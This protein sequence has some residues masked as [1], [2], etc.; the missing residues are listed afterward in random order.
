M[1]IDI[2]DALAE[3]IKDSL[4]TEAHNANAGKW[5]R[6]QLYA[7]ARRHF[8]SDA[9][10]GQWLKDTFTDPPAGH[11]DSRQVINYLLACLEYLSEDEFMRLGYTKSAELMHKTMWRDYPEQMGELARIGHEFTKEQIR[12][13]VKDIKEGR[14]TQAPVPVPTP[15]N[16]DRAMF[17]ELLTNRLTTDYNYCIQWMGGTPEIAADKKEANKLRKSAAQRAKDGQLGD[18]DFEL[19][20]V[21]I[22]KETIKGHWM[23]QDVLAQQLARAEKNASV[24]ER[25]DRARAA[26]AERTANAESSESSEPTES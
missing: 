13:R 9:K 14:T 16:A 15:M 11:K 10:F 6:A 1:S 2:L 18:D 20:C 21:N 3:Q 17:E 8:R 25:V 12:Q 19:R 4:H 24:G 5:R 23:L 26:H 22:I 7:A